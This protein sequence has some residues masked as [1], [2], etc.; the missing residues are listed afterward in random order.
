MEYD[1]GS[2]DSEAATVTTRLATEDE[3]SVILG[4]DVSGAAVASLQVANQH[5]VP[6][7]VTIRFFRLIY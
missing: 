1:Y 2:E 3:V 5:E 4:P 7:T 6:F